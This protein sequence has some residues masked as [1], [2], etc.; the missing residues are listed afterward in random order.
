ME[1]RKSTINDIDEILSIFDYAR[2]YM[3]THGNAT[4]WGAGYPGTDVLTK[5]IANG[6]SY[7]MIA[8]GMI[9]GTFSFIVGDEPTYQLIDNGTWNYNKPYGTI[10]R[11]A[12]NGMCKGIAKACFDFCSNQ[13][14]YMR[15][16]TH[17]D[18]LTMQAAIERYGF[19]KCGTIYVR[20]GAK[21]IAFDY[22]REKQEM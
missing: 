3:V 17:D 2:E 19:Q 21:R 15:I 7:V 10:H 14:D 13:I 5:D 18:N 22:L 9:V 8:N 1:I 6:D 20:N 11:L 12:S 16:D 4:Q